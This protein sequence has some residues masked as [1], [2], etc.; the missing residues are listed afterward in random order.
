MEYTGKLIKTVVDIRYSASP[1][2]AV[3][4]LVS[5]HTNGNW[6]NTDVSYLIHHIEHTFNI[7]IQVEKFMDEKK[8]LTSVINLFYQETLNVHT[9]Q[10][11]QV[12]YLKI[13][14]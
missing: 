12:F 13:Y 7:L 1:I 5:N 10:V 3:H 4:D 8:R 6:S 9:P 11:R 14:G 2:Q